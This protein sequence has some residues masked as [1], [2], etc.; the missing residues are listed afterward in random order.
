MTR[1]HSL[2]YSV[3]LLH[4]LHLLLYILQLMVYLLDIQ[5]VESTTEISFA[6]VP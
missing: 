3:L 6:T 5:S 4:L 2:K 1:I